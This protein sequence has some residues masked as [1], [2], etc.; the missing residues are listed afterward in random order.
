M[1]FSDCADTICILC[2]EYHNL[3]TYCMYGTLDYCTQDSTSANSERMH[4][5]GAVCTARV[6]ACI[7]SSYISCCTHSSFA[8]SR[9]RRKCER[10]QQVVENPLVIGS[11]TQNS[12][13]V[14]GI[15]C[16]HAEI[17]HRGALEID[18]VAQSDCMGGTPRPRT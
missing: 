14:R 15:V 17:V 16:C 10:Y 3:V 9:E 4:I 6:P 2:V 18:Q 13:M 7:H 5:I 8:K 12:H 11:V 1:N